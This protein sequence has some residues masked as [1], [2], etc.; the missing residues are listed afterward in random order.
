MALLSVNDDLEITLPLKRFL[1]LNDCPAK[2]RGLDLYLFRDADI[3]FYVGQSSLAFARVWQH[4]RNGFHG[5]SLVGRFMWCNWPKSLN[6]QIELLS[7]RA[8]RFAALQHDLKAAE[9]DLIHRWSPCFNEALN[10]QPTPLP[11]CYIR[12]NAP[13]RCSRSLRQLTREADRAVKLEERQQW[14]AERDS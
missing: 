6:Y 1:L 14:L 3:V 5:H 10:R 9:A 11:T 8:G 12:P 4:L 2:W 13:L 7:S